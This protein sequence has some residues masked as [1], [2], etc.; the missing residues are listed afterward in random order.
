MD[1]DDKDLIAEIQAAVTKLNSLCDEAVDR[2]IV[3]TIEQ[4]TYD[5]NGLT[6]ISY[7]LRAAYK[8]LITPL[9]ARL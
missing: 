5:F 2:D 4:M 8:R 1:K 3:L 7:K 9:I 6:R